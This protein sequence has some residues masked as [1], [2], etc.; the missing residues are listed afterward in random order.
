MEERY[1]NV[2]EK[3]TGKSYHEIDDKSKVQEVFY[4]RPSVSKFDEFR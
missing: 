4:E 1:L 2:S 3:Q